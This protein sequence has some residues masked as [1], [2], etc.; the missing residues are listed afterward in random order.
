MNQ[1]S[2]LNMKKKHKKALDKLSSNKVH[3]KD[4]IKRYLKEVMS[5]STSDHDIALSLAIGSFITITPHPGLSI[6]FLLIVAF[7]YKKANKLALFGSMILWNPLTVAPIYFAGYKIGEEIIGSTPQILFQ[8]AWLNSS[9]YFFIKLFSG[10]V[11]LAFFIAILMYF[12]TRAYII[13]YRR[14]YFKGNIKKEEIYKNNQDKKQ[15]K[16]RLNRKKSAKPSDKS[17]RI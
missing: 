16:N 2:D 15:V 4:R 8:S 13:F 6:I 9:Y 10:V 17:K 14:G 5:E 11:I 7:I 3:I 12:L 1:K